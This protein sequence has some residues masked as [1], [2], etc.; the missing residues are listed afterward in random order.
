MTE[1]AGPMAEYY[2]PNFFANTPGHQSLLSPDERPGRF[3][4]ARHARGHP[5]ERLGI[6]NGFEICEGRPIPGKEE[7]PDSEKYEIKAL[8]YDWPGNIREHIR[9]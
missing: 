8:D 1:L 3:H 7:Y 4:R 2:R 6:Y 5:L 9:A